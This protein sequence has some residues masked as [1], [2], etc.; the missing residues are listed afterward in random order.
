MGEVYV[1]LSCFN[2]FSFHNY[3]VM[4]STVTYSL[5][6]YT[7]DTN[8]DHLEIVRVE[9]AGDDFIETE[10]KTVIDQANRPQTETQGYAKYQTLERLCFIPF[11][12]TEKEVENIAHIG[13]FLVTSKVLRNVVKRCRTLSL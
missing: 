11:P 13:V 12:N 5:Q 10:R 9:I 6:I 7:P 8:I 4:M 3:L 1:V 2:S